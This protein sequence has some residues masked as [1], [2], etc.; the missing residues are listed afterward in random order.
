MISKEELYEWRSQTAEKPLS[1]ALRRV[2]NEMLEVIRQ[3][4][5]VLD[6][7]QP[8]DQMPRPLGQI[9]R[10]MVADL[11]S[12]RKQ[13]TRM[14]QALQR[15]RDAGNADPQIEAWMRR[16][17]D[18]AL[19]SSGDIPPM[20]EV[21]QHDPITDNP[22]G[23]VGADV[24]YELP[25]PPKGETVYDQIV[26]DVSELPDRSSPTG[27]PDAM[28][29]TSDELREILTER[30]GAAGEPVD[31]PD[32]VA[33]LR[34]LISAF[35]DEVDMDNLGGHTERAVQAAQDVLDRNAAGRK[36]QG[37][38]EC[39]HSRDNPVYCLY[40]SGHEPFC[41]LTDRTEAP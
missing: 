32:A 31:A 35:G 1:E 4:E 2:S 16:I 12:D 36:S 11:Q 27:W 23:H 22:A 21:C 15:L 7:Y 30:L 41:T 13:N 14:A 8:D 9:I 3:I 33:A 39:P 18:Q 37:R 19:A 25:Y 38:P 40:C 5:P 34:N 6:W 24:V 29:V 28:L 26:R 10:D 20:K 17:I